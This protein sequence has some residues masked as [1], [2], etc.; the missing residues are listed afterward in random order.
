MTGPRYLLVEISMTQMDGKKNRAKDTSDRSDSEQ[1]KSWQRSWR[2]SGPVAK[3]TVAFAGFAAGATIIYA[4]ASVWQL[5]EL[6]RSIKVSTDALVTIKE[7]FRLDQRPYV[8][9]SKIQMVDIATKKISAPVKGK[10]LLVNLYISN[11]GKSPALNVMTHR[12]LVFGEYIFKQLKINPPDIGRSHQIIAQGQE[13]IVVTAVSIKD[14]FA[15]ETSDISTSEVLQWDGTS[16]IIVF[17]R[18][19]YEDNFGELYCTPFLSRYLYPEM[20]A[21]ESTAAVTARNFTF[22][23]TDLCPAGKTF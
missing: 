11:V 13:G 2:S 19:T 14:T 16:P 7:Q 15:N 21:R 20:W 8:I 10:P 1:P 18:I 17:G 6:K 9:V 4:F 3:L 23:T 12:H 5:I 22:V